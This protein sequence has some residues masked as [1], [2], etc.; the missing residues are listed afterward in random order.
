M[1]ACKTNWRW[2]DKQT[3]RQT[4]SVKELLSQVNCNSCK[5]CKNS[6]MYFA[7]VYRKVTKFCNVIYLL[8]FLPT[9]LT[10]CNYLPKLLYTFSDHTYPLYKVT[11]HTEYWLNIKDVLTECSNIIYTDCTYWIGPLTV[12]TDNI[13]WLYLLTALTDYA[14]S[15]YLLADPTVKGKTAWYCM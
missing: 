14:Y 9:A 10:K 4:L 15:F 2:T 3:D 6:Q 7:K 13:Y 5:I 12:L 1:V 8:T 11:V